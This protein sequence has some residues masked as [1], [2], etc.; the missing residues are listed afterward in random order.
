[1]DA[2]PVGGLPR[3]TRVTTPPEG[4]GRTQ[5]LLVGR[6]LPGVVPF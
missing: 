6:A 1:M 5:R 2:C 4:T 3:D